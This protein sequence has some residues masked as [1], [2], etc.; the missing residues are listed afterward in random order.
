MGNGGRSHEVAAAA[1][2]LDRDG[3]LN[4]VVYDT[5][6]GT[7]EAPSAPADVTLVPGAA[8]ALRLLSAAGFR[9]VVVSNQPGAA[10]GNVSQATLDAVHRAVAHAL[11]AG[12]AAIDAWRY[13]FHHS[14]AGDVCDCRKPQPGLLVEA[15]HTLG[16]DLA[17]SW[18]IGDADTD[19]EAGRRVGCR[20]ALVLNPLTAHRRHGLP[21]EL[22]GSTLAEVTRA[23]LERSGHRAQPTRP[24]A[25]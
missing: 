9:L 6:T 22:T 2:F 20:T 12:G 19:V 14:D 15:A 1:I 23:I 25:P 21:A 13:C 8:E 18:M 10:K 17:A 3:V 11:D 16:L 5:R 24:I 4:E 7:C